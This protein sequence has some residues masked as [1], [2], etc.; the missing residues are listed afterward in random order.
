MTHTERTQ[1]E[2]WQYNEK[3]PHSP[4]VWSSV[5]R[6]DELIEWKCPKTLAV[7]QGRI[8][9]VVWGEGTV[10]SDFISAKVR[11]YI[12]NIVEVPRG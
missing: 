5:P 4:F 6:E 11:L 9:Q 1:V 8:T 2:L 10:Y 12:L 3:I 7:Y